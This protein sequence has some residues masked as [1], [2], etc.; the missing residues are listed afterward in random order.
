MREGKMRT[1]KLLELSD[2]D[3]IGIELSDGTKIEIPRRS[4]K[5]IKIS[6][7]KGTVCIAGSKDLMEVSLLGIL[8]SI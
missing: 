2:W 6:R 7:G 4:R 5:A 1:I 8:V 3:A